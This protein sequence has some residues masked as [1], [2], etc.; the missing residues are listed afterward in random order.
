VVAGAASFALLLLTQG[1]WT[2]V[3]YLALTAGV[4]VTALVLGVLRR[5]VARPL[6]LATGWLLPPLVVIG[7][8]LWWTGAL[9]DYFLTR[10][11]DPEV[12]RANAGA[13]HD[14]RTR[15]RMVEDL[16]TSGRLD[17]ITREEAVLLLGEPTERSRTEPDALVWF[18]G[19]GSFI[20]LKFLRLHFDADGRVVRHE[21]FDT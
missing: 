8:L 17:R 3:V 16:R 11:F 19:P 7:G 21:V 4:L 9:G 15:L 18:V 13:D 12:W 14:D 6:A 1:P 2:W 10:S 5:K 20:D